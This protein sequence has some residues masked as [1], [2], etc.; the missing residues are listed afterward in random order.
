MLRKR[1][2]ALSY[3]PN[4]EQPV[5]K[6]LYNEVQSKAEGLNVSRRLFYY[7]PS[8]VVQR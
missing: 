1:A 2:S 3:E 4:L 6:C 7:D 5:R 8:G